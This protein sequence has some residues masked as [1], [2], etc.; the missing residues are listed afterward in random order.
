MSALSIIAS[1]IGWIYFACWSLS[2]YPQ[3]YLNFKKK[4]VLGLSFDFL[5]FNI[6]GYMCYSVFN[7][8][9]Y[10]DKLVQNEYLEK[11]APPLPVYASDV[12]FAIHG[13]IL[14]LI[15]IVQCF[16]YERGNQK[17]SKIGVGIGICIWISMI[18]VTI[19]GFAKVVSWLWVIYFYSYVK[20][21]ITFIKY[22]PQAYINYKNKS[23][24]G[25][26]IGNVLL[27]FSGGVLS[28]LQMFLDVAESSNWKIFTG[29]PVKLG[30]SLFSIA[31][32]ILFMIQHYILYR[33]P[34]LRGYKNL[35]PDGENPEIN[36]NNNNYTYNNNKDNNNDNN[37][38]D[39]TYEN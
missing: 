3:V 18:V 14:T 37:N 25:W 13:F 23:T 10:W 20:L 28:L 21:F 17:N 32:D 33:H 7:S 26:S 24:S 8:V 29:D 2:F 22:V 16:V 35:N 12:A 1:I 5:L 9:L 31:F 38:N 19:L 34:S 6:T 39:T 36:S 11:Y 4:N 30:L 15:T 27:D